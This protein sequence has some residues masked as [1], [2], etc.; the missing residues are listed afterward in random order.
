MIDRTNITNARRKSIIG[1][2]R[3]ICC[4][5]SQRERVGVGENRSDENA[6]PVQ[7]EGM[8]TSGGQQTTFSTQFIFWKR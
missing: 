1:P 3:L 4:S 2:I 6:L 8:P 5:L 7:D